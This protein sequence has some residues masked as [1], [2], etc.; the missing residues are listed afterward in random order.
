L[1]GVTSAVNEPRNLVLAAMSRS[2]RHESGVAVGAI[3]AGRIE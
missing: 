2:N 3:R 1:N